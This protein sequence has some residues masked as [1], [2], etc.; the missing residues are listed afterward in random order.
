MFSQN[1]LLI[2]LIKAL[3][4]GAFLGCLPTAPIKA[5]END[6]AAQFENTVKTITQTLTRLKKS[7]TQDD[8]SRAPRQRQNV[9]T[10]AQTQLSQLQE[11]FITDNDKIEADFASIEQSL[12][13]LQLPERHHKRHEAT[14]E[15]YRTQFQ[16][17]LDHLEGIATADSSQT[18]GTQIDK[19]ST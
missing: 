5:L 4:F 19:A 11:Q 17:L 15:H 1:T 2:K 3:F 18:L 12:Y 7:L 10:F 13:D 14:V 9:P 6:S 8:T 16:T